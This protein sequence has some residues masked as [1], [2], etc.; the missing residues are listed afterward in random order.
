MTPTFSNVFEG[1][2][3]IFAAE[4]MDALGV[5]R[6]QLHDTRYP[7]LLARAVRFL[8]TEPNWR[9]TV[10]KV[11]HGKPMVDPLRVMA[12]YADLRAALASAQKRVEE[13]AASAEKLSLVVDQAHPELLSARDEAEAAQRALES[14]YEEVKIYEK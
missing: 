8:A 11:L 14:V 3:P 4:V 5:Q 2:D 6:E 12:E 1:L 9:L 7:A 10:S 13:S